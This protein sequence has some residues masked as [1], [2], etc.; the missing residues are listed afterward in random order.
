MIK[1]KT[2]VFINKRLHR[3]HV[4]AMSS[5]LIFLHR[6]INCRDSATFT[7]QML[8]SLIPERYVT[9]IA[10][11]ILPIAV[12]SRLPFHYHAGWPEEAIFRVRIA[13]SRS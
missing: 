5:T 4:L 1:I 3:R 7:M 6:E 11:M 9:V 2:C 12:P 10:I 13:A 8:T